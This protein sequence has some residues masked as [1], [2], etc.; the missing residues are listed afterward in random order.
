M[1]QPFR[2]LFYGWRIIV[3]EEYNLECAKKNPE[4]N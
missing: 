3:I 1:N 2:I 4:V